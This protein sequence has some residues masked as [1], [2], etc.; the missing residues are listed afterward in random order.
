MQLFQREQLRVD[1]GQQAGVERAEQPGP[2][3][4]LGGLKDFLAGRIRGIDIPGQLVVTIAVVSSSP[5]IV[6]P[7]LA[8]ERVATTPMAA[9]PATTTENATQSATRELVA[10]LASVRINMLPNPPA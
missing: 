7:W 4:G 3:R 2:L 5:A 8:A 10:A 1:R 9:T 6:L